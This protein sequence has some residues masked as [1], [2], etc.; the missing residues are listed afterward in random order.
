M[1]RIQRLSRKLSYYSLLTVLQNFD[2]DLEIR[3]GGRV[4]IEDRKG[5]ERGKM[6][7]V[8]IIGTVK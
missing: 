5:Q 2:D 7:V 4:T 6:E 8:R 1:S 3:V